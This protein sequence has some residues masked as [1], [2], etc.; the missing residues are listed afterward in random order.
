VKACL[1]L[2]VQADGKEITTIEGLEDNGVL[3]PTRGIRA[4]AWCAVRVLYTGMGWRAIPSASDAKSSE[5]T[6]VAAFRNSACTVICRLCGRSS[7]RRRCCRARG[8]KHGRTAQIPL[9]GQ[10]RSKEIPTC[11]GARPI[12]RRSAVRGLTYAAL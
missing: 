7:W 1:M 3:H 9:P 4:G 6:T 2:A 12:Y 11:A 8:T 5:E 10:T